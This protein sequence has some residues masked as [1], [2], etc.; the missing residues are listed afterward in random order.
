MPRLVSITLAALTFLVFQSS[1]NGR[2]IT[3]P[4]TL[5]YQLLDALLIQS[6]YTDPG[7]TAQLLYQ[8]DGC[9]ELRLSDPQ[10][11]GKADVVSLLSKVY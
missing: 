7:Q 6:S 1:A 11:S 9:L 2:D 8:A 3:L 4:I 5:D 10:F